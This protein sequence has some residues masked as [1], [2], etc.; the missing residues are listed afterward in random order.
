MIRFKKSRGK[1]G[2]TQNVTIQVLLKIQIYKT[3]RQSCMK[4][5][6]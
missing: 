4:D 1:K 5:D 6:L 3:V 2:G